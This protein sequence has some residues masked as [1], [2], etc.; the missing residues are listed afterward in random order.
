MGL[1]KITYWERIYRC[2]IALHKKMQKQI[3][4]YMI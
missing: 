4:V 2:D 1:P 3:L